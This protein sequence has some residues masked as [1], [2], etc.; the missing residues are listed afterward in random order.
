MT[1]FKYASVTFTLLFLLIMQSLAADET[2]QD[3]RYSEVKIYFQDKNQ[4]RVL[5][6]KGLIFDHVKYQKSADGGFA[7]KTVIN[8]RELD[9]LKK[10]PLDYEILIDDVVA[11][12]REKSVRR[13]GQIKKIE[14]EEAPAGFELG[15]MGGYYTFDEVV[16]EL[17]SMYLLY[18]QL[19]T[20]K[21][22]IGQS[23]ESRNL[24]MVKIS[25][26]P[27]VDEDEPEVFI[28]ALHHAREPAGMMAVIYFM[29]HLLE[30]YGS[31]PEATY[32]I[33][34]REIYFVPVINP[35]GYVYNETNDP[36]G[37]GQWRKNR[38][39][40]D[41]GSWYGV[42]LNRNYGYK[43]GYDDAGSSPYPMSDTYRGP[44][45]FSEPE[46]QAVR[47]FTEGRNFVLCLS[48]HTYSNVLIYPWSY[49]EN[50]LTPDSLTYLDYACDLTIENNYGYGT[51]DET[52]N[53]VVNG[54][55]DDWF[56][57][58]Q[59][60]KNKILAMTPEVGSDADG[61]WPEP[62]RIIPLCEENLPANLHLSWL[63][64]G[65]VKYVSF[66]I[67]DEGNDNGYADPGETADILFK[68]RNMGQDAARNVELWIESDD[69]YL[70]VISASPTEAVDIPAQSSV[71]GQSL[72]FSVSP[73]APQGYQAALNLHINMDGYESATE[74]NGITIGTPT[75]LFAD[76]AESGMQHWNTNGGWN[77][78]DKTAS[79]GE[80]AFTDSPGAYY[81]AN[82][83]NRLTLTNPVLLPE[84][85]ALYL[86]FNSRWLIERDYDFGRVEVSADGSN[87]TV[88]EG[89]LT[90]TGSGKGA[91]NSTD[92]GYD[93]VQLE[94][95]KEQ[96]DLSDYTDSTQIYIRF[97]L[98]SD[99]GLER[100]GWY[101]DDIRLLAY[102]DQPS[103]VDNQNPAN[104]K[105]FNLARNYPNPFNSSTVIDFNLPRA[106]QIEL[107]VY[108]ILGQQIRI[109]VSG[110][111]E[112]GSHT[113]RWD[114]RDDKNRPVNSG[115]YF[116][117]L[118][119]ENQIQ[120]KKMLYVE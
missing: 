33:D 95:V 23:H 117:R 62:E 14:T 76:D 110:R 47:D 109:L 1:G 27:T 86:T 59:A 112:G 21:V 98:E 19:I 116:Y 81:A 63:A 111:R 78:T 4:V 65:F 120:V 114:G 104:P 17:D 88:R 43:W 30:N 89:F 34:N 36:D 58:E 71:V 2:Q 115:V 54:D 7:Y 9:V 94:W 90:T 72:R 45:A 12:Y 24:W 56:Y 50:F 118:K 83:E 85:G 32:L 16:A 93:D 92:Y 100:D 108:N 38:R 105:T 11:D 13:A 28:N 74:V 44:S 35:D 69:P 102:D 101:L 61:F 106:G 20:E 91:Q 70:S 64:G 18:P 51:A 75:M 73:D 40:P 15:S 49:E 107:A 84:A 3:T 52:I 41:Q 29:Y 96:I 39:P 99:G 8:N 77:V 6:E 119:M 37:G 26:N 53:Y 66:E 80:N 48:Y 60:T 68:I 82:M 25:D 42:D 10:S 55:S 113:V 79:N 67:A 57:G 87:W 5:A 46:T 22:S 97:N 103:F 31:D